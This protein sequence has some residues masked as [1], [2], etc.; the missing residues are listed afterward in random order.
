[1]GYANIIGR[2]NEISTLE[3]RYNSNKSEFIVIYG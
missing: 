1:M 2:K 3:R